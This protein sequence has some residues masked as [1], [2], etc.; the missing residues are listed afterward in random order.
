MGIDR[1]ILTW[2]LVMQGI[3]Q[4]NILDLMKYK[5]FYLEKEIVN[6]VK[7]QSAEIFANYAPEY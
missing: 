2:I 1:D 3:T 6:Q 5:S 4:M 7:K